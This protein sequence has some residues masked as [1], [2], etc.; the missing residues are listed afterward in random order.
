MSLP[1]CASST[2]V[3]RRFSGFRGQRAV[4]GYDD[5]GQRDRQVRAG[6]P[7]E[8]AA[9]V[10]AEVKRDP[11]S[12][13]ATSTARG[14][15]EGRGDRRP[16]PTREC[17]LGTSSSPRRRCVAEHA[18]TKP[19]APPRTPAAAV[20]P[21]RDRAQPP[22][23]RLA[24]RGLVREETLRSAAAY[25]EASLTCTG[26]RLRR[27]SLPARATAS[28]LA[29]RARL[30]ERAERIMGKLEV[31]L[32]GPFEVVV[33]GQPVEVPGAKRQALVACLAL[34]RR[35]SRA[36]GHAG[37]G[38]V[39]ERP[40]GGA[41]KRRAAPRRPAAPGAGRRRDPARRR[42]VR[43]RRRSRWTPSS[44]RSCSR[45][46]RAALRA[47]DARGAADTIADALALWRGPALLGLPQS[48]WAT[49]EAGR[50]D[51]AAARRAGGAV[52]GGSRARRARRPR[53]RHTRCARREPVPRAA[54]GAAD[55]GA[56]PQRPPGGRARGL[57]GGPA[58]PHGASWRSSPAPSCGGSR[59]RSS[60]TTRRSRP[61][62]LHRGGAATCPLR[63]PRSST[64]RRSSPRCV[65]LLREH[66]LVTLTG[67][68]GVGKSR[69]A[70]EAARSLESE[71][72]GGAWHVD[73]A[74]AQTRADVVRLVAQAVD[75][76][77]ADPLARVVARLRDTDAILVFDACEHVLE[78]TARVVE[79]FSPSC[80]GVRLLATSREV[81]HVAGEVR[82]TVEPL[83][84]AG[85][86]IGRRRRLP[87]RRALHRACACGAP[88]L[89]A[90]GRGRLARR[91]DQPSRRRP[92]ARDRARRRAGQRA[93]ACGAPLPRRAPPRA[94]PR[95]AGIGRRAV[96]R[97]RRS[98]SG[99]TTSCTRTRRRCSTRSRC[100]EAVR[101]CRRSS[102]PAPSHGLDEATVRPAARRAR[103]QVDR[104]GLVPERRRALRPARH[105]PRLRARASCRGRRS[106]RCAEGAR[107]VLRGAG[108]LRA[109]AELRG[110]DWQR[111]RQTARARARQPLGRAR[112][113]A[114]CTGLGHRDPTGRARLVLHARGARLR[115]TSLRRARARLRVRGCSGRAPTRAGGVPLLPR[116]GRARPRRGDRRSANARSPRPSRDRRS[117]GSRRGGALARPRRVR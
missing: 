66:R 83:A 19:R 98:S 61:S 102:P 69:L 103:R 26:G 117:Q 3:A 58:G 49:A 12:R 24:R 27:A 76:R 78:E 110:P 95:S 31:R 112:V 59:R 67:P 114:R 62:R 18:R 73:L 96:P 94:A 35:S 33:A 85:P 10:D 79:P 93:R 32:L 88:R 100:T 65:E 9:S 86:R 15:I 115:G 21:R 47:G 2:A 30:L 25:A 101:L 57:P 44:S 109:R 72:R 48:T 106:R 20:Q 87:G 6:D 64:A 28:H 34:A 68:P 54:V 108:G 36:D 51:V 50:L 42:R 11:P 97:S 45:A 60:R 41:S 29:R 52:R 111:L 55:A 99:A 39:G 74:R 7:E 53:A 38:A 46:A 81:L 89:R 104:H 5:R 22:G 116:D 70:L 77:G 82:V 71:L 63:R 40:S 56:L 16:E 37:R 4:D 90:D 92:T 80:P 113:R 107:G 8:R 14:R 17:V 84:A 91:G 13:D 75:A 43:A 23:T 1:C 105:R